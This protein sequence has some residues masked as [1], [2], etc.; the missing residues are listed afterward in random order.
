M[1]VLKNSKGFSLAEILIVLGLMAILATVVVLNSSNSSTT[2]KENALKANVA[3]LREALDLYRADHGWYP[4][5]PDRDYNK[6]GD[7][8]VLAFQLLGFTNDEGEPSEKKTTEFRFGPYLRKWPAE[9]LTDTQDIVVDNKSESMLT[10]L[11]EKVAKGDGKGGW[12]YEPKSGNI[13]ANLGNQY[14]SD[15]ATY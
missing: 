6:K 7:A 13:C 14:P 15:Y 9:P 4:A 2:A 3:V 11:A 1:R 5:D 10:L 12:Y 8:E